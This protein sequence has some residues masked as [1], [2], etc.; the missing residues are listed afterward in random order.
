MKKVIAINLFVGFISCATNAF[1]W[2]P[3]AEIKQQTNSANERSRLCN[4]AKNSPNYKGTDIVGG[5]Y[6]F[7]VGEGKVIRYSAFGKLASCYHYS[8]GAPNKTGSICKVMYKLSGNSLV[9]YESCTGYPTTKLIYQSVSSRS[10]IA[11]QS[12]A[13]S[14]RQSYGDYLKNS[15]GT[16]QNTPPS[17]TPS[18]EVE[19]RRRAFDSLS[20]Y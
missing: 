19:R 8:L 17:N 15:Y 13:N 16:S 10:P 7:Y 3:E 1:A 11:P 4:L 14:A 20:N 6:R 2:D 9:H 12:R 5:D 18:Q